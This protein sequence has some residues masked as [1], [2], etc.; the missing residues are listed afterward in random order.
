VHLADATAGH[1]TQQHGLVL[2]LLLLLLF[3]GCDLLV[4]YAKIA[5]LLAPACSNAPAALAAAAAAL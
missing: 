3:L 4:C 1:D 5:S 2:L